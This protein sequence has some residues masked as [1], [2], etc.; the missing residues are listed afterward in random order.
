MNPC[1]IPE[2]PV[3]IQGDNRWM[4][5]VYNFKFKYLVILILFDIFISMNVMYLK[6]KNVNLMLL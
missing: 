3:D 4:S 6:Q 5:Q 2:V 1:I